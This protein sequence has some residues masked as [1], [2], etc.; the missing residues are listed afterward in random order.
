M[1]NKP[2]EQCTVYRFNCTPMACLNSFLSASV[3]CGN[4]LR[5]SCSRLCRPE[6][7]NLA[8]LSLRTT[9]APSPPEAQQYLVPCELGQ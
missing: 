4:I 3:R 8:K 6:L 1:N 7:R 2:T 9:F 5:S